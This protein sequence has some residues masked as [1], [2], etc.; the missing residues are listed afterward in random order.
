MHG[1]TKFHGFGV[2]LST[3]LQRE[4][5]FVRDAQVRFSP[6]LRWNSSLLSPLSVAPCMSSC[7]RIWSREFPRNRCA[8]LLI[9]LE[10]EGF[11]RSWRASLLFSPA[12]E[13]AGIP[14]SPSLLLLNRCRMPAHTHGR[15]KAR[16]YGACLSIPLDPK[17][18]IGS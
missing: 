17:D 10:G 12:N 14:L 5:P 4:G 6:P 7:S 13:A 2:L 1:R 16:R 11:V 3:P 9:P 8:A 15:M 18:S